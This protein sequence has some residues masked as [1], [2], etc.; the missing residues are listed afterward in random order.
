MDQY[1]EYAATRDPELRNQLIVQHHPLV[2]FIARRMMANL[3]EHIELDD[4][5]TWG[6][7]GLIDAIGKFQ[8]EKGYQFSTYAFTRIRGDILDGLQE[9]EWAPKHVHSQV[10]KMRRVR[11]ELTNALGY[12]PSNEELAAALGVTVEDV[13]KALVDDTATRM[14]ELPG[15]S[16]NSTTDDHA[17]QVADHLA[18]EQQVAGQVAELRGYMVGAVRS[19]TRRQKAMILGYYQDGLTLKQIAGRMGVSVSVANTEHTRLVEELRE[20]LA[21]AGGQ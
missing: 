14:R 4:L 1:E 2:K 17:D 7:F 18:E 10:R 13:R 11:E 16:H 21:L 6:T 9:M 20:R 15:Q 5:V 12:E 19:L 3:P 8:P